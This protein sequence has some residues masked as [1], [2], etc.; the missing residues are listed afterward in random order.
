MVARDEPKTQ[1]RS[2]LAGGVVVV[3][4]VAMGFGG[5]CD[6]LVVLFTEV[7]EV[8]VIGGKWLCLR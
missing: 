1:M 7:H 5:C 6:G 3:V 2:G 4:V 8:T